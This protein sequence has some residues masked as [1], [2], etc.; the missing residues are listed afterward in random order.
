VHPQI[1][2][3]CAWKKSLHLHDG[4]CHKE[5]GGGGNEEDWK[6]KNSF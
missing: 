4:K 3:L 5:S 1:V 6:K 2:Q